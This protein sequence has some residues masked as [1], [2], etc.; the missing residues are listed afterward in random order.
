MTMFC[1]TRAEVDNCR[2]VEG[3]AKHVSPHE[4]LPDVQTK[5]SFARFLRL[6]YLA[7]NHRVQASHLTANRC[8]Y[9]GSRP[10]IFK[11]PV[12]YSTV[13]L[14]PLQVTHKI[15]HG[16]S[17]ASPHTCE[18]EQYS[19]LHAGPNPLSCNKCKLEWCPTAP[20]LAP[21]NRGT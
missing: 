17:V 3:G 19:L 4:V 16:S 12:M 21:V 7:P 8:I 10:T 9:H 13:N 1:F 18:P 6:L 11:L 15:S 5:F 14:S 2:P 20:E